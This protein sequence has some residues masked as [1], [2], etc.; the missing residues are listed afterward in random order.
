M[1]STTDV[2]SR[3]PAA[4]SR[5]PTSTRPKPAMESEHSAK[6]CSKYSKSRLPATKNCSKSSF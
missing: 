4:K 6:T 5:F 1:E 2:Q 3:F